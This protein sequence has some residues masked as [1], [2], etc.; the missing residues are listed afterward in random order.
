M[1]EQSL[2]AL[3]L[4]S[5]AV[6]LGF[7]AVLVVRQVATK[8]EDRARI[9]QLEAQIP[10]LDERSREALETAA[11]A[12]RIAS[13]RKDRE[14]RADARGA[15]PPEPEELPTKRVKAAVLDDDDFHPGRGMFAQ[16]KLPGGDD[17]AAELE[18][19]GLR[20]GENGTVE[21]A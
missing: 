16:P 12:K 18:R 3:I 10:A 11:G 17:A 15:Q 8:A 9:A 4:I 13:K 1:P 19:R 7:A 5:G 21:P 20:V 6:L 2:T 14:D